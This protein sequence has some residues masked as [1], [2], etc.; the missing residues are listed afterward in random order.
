MKNNK[1]T[2]LIVTLLVISSGAFAQQ[3]ASTADSLKTWLTFLASDQMKGRD[4]G[5]PEV[6]KAAQW[7]AE[8][9]KTY[10]LKPID[11]LQGFFQ[12]YILDGDSSFVH[13]N[14]VGYI[15]AKKKKNNFSGKY[16]LISSHFDG[17]GMSLNAVN[18]DSI[19][20]G[21]D[22]NAS[23]TAALLAIAKNLH[24]HKIKPEIPIVFA[25]FS[26]E[27]TGLV[28]SNIFC[29]SGVIPLQH[30]KLNMNLEMLGHSNEYGRNKF[31]ITG[32]GYSNF[33]NVITDFN[34]NSNWE[35]INIGY[36]ANYY[37]RMSDNYSF[38]QCAQE[39]DICVS[40]HTIFTSAKS[41]GHLHGVSDE[42]EFIDFENYSALIEYLTQLALHVTKNDIEIQCS[43]K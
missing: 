19:F 41:G 32:P 40:A 9:Y 26:N 23:G 34:K 3:K 22:D 43:K 35:L 38:V 18:G 28:G 10:G 42:V 21:A 29:Q 37:F 30:M 16:I 27:E 20:N 1:F 6:E 24:E 15:P 5:T 7:L 4:N 8:K 2:C 17:I 36:L 39:A 11:G 33:E 12:P 25:A 14:V 13:K 31:F